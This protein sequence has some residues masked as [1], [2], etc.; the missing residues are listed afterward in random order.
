MTLEVLLAFRLA[1]QNLYPS[2]FGVSGC[3][4][5]WERDC[6]VVVFLDYLVDWLLRN[7]YSGV[8]LQVSK[9]GQSDI[10]HR[11]DRLSF[12]LFALLIGLVS[13]LHFIRVMYLQLLI[14]RIFEPICPMVLLQ[15]LSD[16]HGKWMVGAGAC[17]RSLFY[18]IACTLQRESNQA[19]FWRRR[20]AFC[21][22][23]L[24]RLD[25][26]RQTYWHQERRLLH[27]SLCQGDKCD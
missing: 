21:Y 7:S 14:S 19:L 18:E 24:H 10:F 2:L 3:T 13:C 11:C 5:D 23:G 20:D 9:E 6:F 27:R 1:W 8:S 12:P 15:C 16:R 25:M 4:S 17:L 26:W 22:R